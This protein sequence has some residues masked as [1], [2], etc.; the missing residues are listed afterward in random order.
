MNASNKSS[1]QQLDA[2]DAFLTNVEM[3]L[4]GP[5]SSLELPRSVQA[6]QLRMQQQQDK[7]HD[8][9]NTSEAAAAVFVA[10]LQKVFEKMDMT[11]RLRSLVALLGF[12]SAQDDAQ[13]NAASYKLLQHAQELTSSSDVWVRVLAGLVQGILFR[14]VSELKNPSER[15]QEEETNSAKEERLIGAEAHQVL[16]TT[17]QTILDQVWELAK[18]QETEASNK[19]TMEADPTFAP[20]WYSLLP[21]DLLQQ[22][23]PEASARQTHAHFTID[24][25]ADIL[26]VDDQLLLEAAANAKAGPDATNGTS[27]T[28]SNTRTTQAAA[29]RTATPHFPGF[30]SSSGQQQRR[31][32]PPKKSSM[33]LPAR[34]PMATAATKT[35]LHTRKKGAAQALVGKG[36]VVRPQSSQAQSSQQQPRL[37]KLGGGTTRRGAAGKSRMKLLDVAQVQELTAASNKTATASTAT[38]TSNKHKPL[39]KRKLGTTTKSAAQDESSA[40]KKPAVGLKPSSGTTT[41]GAQSATHPNTSTNTATDTV[42]ATATTTKDAANALASAALSAYQAQ[43]MAATPAAPAPAAAAPA[44]PAPTPHAHKQQD[45]R[46]LL[47]EKSNKLSQDDRFRIQQFFVDRFNPTPNQP[48]YKMKLHEERMTDPNTQQPVKETYYLE[49]DYTNFTSRQSKKVKRY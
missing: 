33:F 19:Q 24:E 31:T 38:A 18:N 22:A 23:L 39:R 9:N 13:L 1:D 45:W 35:T 36:R 20:Y 47:Q 40:R 34:K 25:S 26:K 16:E 2:L 10:Q 17:C 4:K 7:Q 41:P 46:E 11:T 21:P 29:R 28:S 43:L 5:F 32:Q 42:D 37:G 27:G 3:K 6:R 12:D 48:T 8:T 44:A 49:L 15:E 30:R 14:K